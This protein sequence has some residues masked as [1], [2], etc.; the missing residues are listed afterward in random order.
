MRR[1]LGKPSRRRPGPSGLLGLQAA[2]YHI[3]MSEAL[4]QHSQT[5]S[6]A[7]PQVT[8]APTADSSAPDI[9]IE[10]VVQPPF[11]L[12][13][14]IGG[15]GIK[16]MLLD[17]TGQPSGKRE[18]RETPRPATPQEVLPVI[19]ELIPALPFARVSVGFP[20][21]V[22]RGVTKTAPN[23]HPT[24]ADFP[25]AKTLED[26]T[27]KPVRVLNDAGVQGFGAISGHGVELVVTLGTG[28]GF[29][30]F[31]GGRYC[32]NIEMAHHPFSKNR[33]YEESLG[34]VA[35][36]KVGNA[37]WN[38]RVRRALKQLQATFNPDVIYLGGGNATK[39]TGELPEGVKVVENIAG[40]LGGIALWKDP[41]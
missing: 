10:T 14:D 41:A 24:W 29:A 39:L 19:R 27:G 22:T 9:G 7:D 4:D 2:C 30:L 28:M 40:L 6:G 34:N 21:V 35:R 32:P 1:A 16:C 25:L 37:T 33:T 36:K 23:L 38:R 17:A 8:A 26:L 20:G 5:A 15:S 18:R 31:V 11:T 12:A 13:I 3:K